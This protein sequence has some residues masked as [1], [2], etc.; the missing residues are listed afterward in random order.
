MAIDEVND[1]DFEYENDDLPNEE[2]KL[3][4]NE[5]LKSLL[6]DPDILEVLKRRQGGEG[7]RIINEEKARKEVE[8][9]DEVDPYD[10]IEDQTARK[11]IDL[12][13]A[14]IKSMVAP[15]AEELE[16]LKGI[17]NGY[18]KQ[19]VDGE[20]LQVKNK[21]EDFD[22]YRKP[23]AELVQNTPGLSIEE[24][25]LI[26]KHRLGELKLPK[27]STQSERPTQTGRR[28]PSKKKQESRRGRKGWQDMMAEALDSVD[29]QTSRSS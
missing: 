26:S 16:A 3:D 9:E 24:Y 12:V 2:P 14:K 4:Q 10:G 11:M 29:L 21:Y 18:Q 22:T 1:T 6:A 13:S 23:M 27:T 19:S 5:F 8:S 28:E 15:M 25:Y 7:G 20:I 17:A